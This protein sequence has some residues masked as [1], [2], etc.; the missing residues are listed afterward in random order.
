[1]WHRVVLISIGIRGGNLPAN[2]NP[3]QRQSAQLLLI[4]HPFF[5]VFWPFF[6]P[7][8]F[9]FVLLFLSFYLLSSLLSTP[10]CFCPFF[11]LFLFAFCSLTPL[12]NMGETIFGQH[13]PIKDQNQLQSRKRRFD[14]KIFF[15]LGFLVIYWQKKGW[16][17]LIN[18]LSNVSSTTDTHWHSDSQ[19]GTSY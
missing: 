12:L 14:G 16:I 5:P 10:F 2:Q 8:L 6:P 1:M 18:E 17:T 19:T 9:A 13:Q 3:N 7:F 11:L 15:I 4:P